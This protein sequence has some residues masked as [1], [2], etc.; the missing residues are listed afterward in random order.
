MADDRRI[1]DA[2]RNVPPPPGLADRVVPEALFDDAALDRLLG[3][4]ALPD[5]L[6]DRVRTAVFAPLRQMAPSCRVSASRSASPDRP[7]TTS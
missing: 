3:R 1:D 5:G 2:L 4:V 7:V 6:S